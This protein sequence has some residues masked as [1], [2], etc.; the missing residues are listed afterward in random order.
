[1]SGNL[2]FFSVPYDEGFTA[3][4]DGQTAEIERVDGGLMAVFVPEGRHSIEFSYY[5]KG[6]KACIVISAAAFLIFLA[7][8]KKE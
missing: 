4:V 8:G 1:M 3:K 5:P 7:L 2:V 6:L